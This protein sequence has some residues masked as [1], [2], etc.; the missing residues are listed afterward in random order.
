MS[1]ENQH[2]VVFYEYEQWEAAATIM[3]F[4]V[5][6]INAQLSK[7]YLKGPEKDNDFMFKR[8]P[9]VL[10]GQFTVQPAFDK[11]IYKGHLY[12]DTSTST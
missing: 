7:A 11:V 10:R 12:V 5:E 6:R 1:E 4:Y 2:K 8:L 9:Q 3:G